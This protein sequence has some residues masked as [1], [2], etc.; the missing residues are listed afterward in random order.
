MKAGHPKKSGDENTKTI[1]E[2]PAKG[3]LITTY[4]PKPETITRK[5][6]NA[7]S[8]HTNGAKGVERPARYKKQ[9]TQ[10]PGKKHNAQKKSE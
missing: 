1:L 3:G 2:T 6:T 10:H 7:R 4:V 8:L 5:R 9:R